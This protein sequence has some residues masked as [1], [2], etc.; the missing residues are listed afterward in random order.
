MFFKAKKVQFNHFKEI[1]VVQN[2]CSKEKSIYK[3]ADNVNA[4]AH[5]F[6]QRHLAAKQGNP[7]R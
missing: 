7:L 5:F 2:I 3:I 1:F 4:A 6:N